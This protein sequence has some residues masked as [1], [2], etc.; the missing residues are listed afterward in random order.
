M[1]EDDTRTKH[2]AYAQKHLEYM[3]KRRKE[4]KEAKKK[5]QAEPRA[6]A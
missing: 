3:Q 4:D 6:I 1:E 2:K 5:K